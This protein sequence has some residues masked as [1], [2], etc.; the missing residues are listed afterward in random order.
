M[1]ET[2]S[3]PPSALVEDLQQRAKNGDA[4]ASLQLGLMY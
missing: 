3:A 4:Q 2:G 1:T